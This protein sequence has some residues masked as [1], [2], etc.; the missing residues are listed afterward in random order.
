M[1]S[2]TPVVFLVFNRPGPTRRVFEAIAKA[3]PAQLLVV[4]DGPRTHRRGEAELCQQVRAIAQNVSW[5]C[6]IRTNFSETNLG[7]PERI[8]S[9]LNWAFDMVEEAIILEDDCLPDPS[10]F[11]F[12]QELLGRYRSDSRV[13][14]IS[15]NNFTGRPLRTGHSYYFSQMTHTWGWATWRATWRRHDRN[16]N[17][18]PEIKRNKLLFE[19]FDDRSLIA[20]W[21]AR[22]EEMH[23]K[24]G[25]Q[26]WDYQWFYTNLVHNSLCITPAVNLVTNIG[27]GP[28]ATHT[29]DPDSPLVLPSHSLDWPLRHPPSLLA[30]RSMDRYEQRLVAPSILIPIRVR[31][32]LRRARRLLKGIRN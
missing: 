30:L 6:E 21:S 4:A 32:K 23:S 11:P 18:W 1:G 12:C 29:F 5:P 24:T 15:G 28:D 17:D 25:P 19:V 10:F 31:E 3:R 13:G 14:M 16:L 20:F 9:G 27:F 8:I 7:G 22:F 2:T 26:P